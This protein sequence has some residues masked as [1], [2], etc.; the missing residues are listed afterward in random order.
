VLALRAMTS[1]CVTDIPASAARPSA[2]WEAMAAAPQPIAGRRAGE[3][4]VVE[5]L[6]DL[7][8]GVMAP[9]SLPTTAAT[10]TLP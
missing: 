3:T 8:D 4:D 6:E 5:G 9:S 10:A 7:G 1:I 2:R